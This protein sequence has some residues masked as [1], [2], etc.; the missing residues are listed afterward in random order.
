[1][2][3]LLGSSIVI[4]ASDWQK[5]SYTLQWG[6]TWKILIKQIDRVLAAEL[7]HE[8]LWFAIYWVTLSIRIY[9]L[10]WFT[11]RVCNNRSL[12]GRRL[13]QM[14]CW[15]ERTA[16]PWQT[17]R[18]HKT[19][20]TWKEKSLSADSNSLF[21]VKYRQHVPQTQARSLQLPLTQSFKHDSNVSTYFTTFLHMQIENCSF[22]HWCYK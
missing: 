18:E 11:R 6:N 22:S 3:I 10:T 14:R 15:L 17:Q 7:E 2:S 19:S 1:M 8:F 9:L 21:I 13:S 20:R 5:N 12:P 4:I 16:T